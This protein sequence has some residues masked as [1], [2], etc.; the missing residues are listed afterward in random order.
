LNRATSSFV[1]E[2]NRL[3]HGPPLFKVTTKSDPH[4]TFPEDL[5]ARRFDQG[6][7]DLVWTSDYTYMTIG[8]GEAYLC[9]IRDE[10]S[11]R[12]LG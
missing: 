12:V 5:V 10:H 9:A 1:S 2:L 3:R 4:A 7:L 8:T 6:A 11:G